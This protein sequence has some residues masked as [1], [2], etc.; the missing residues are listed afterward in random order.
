MVHNDTRPCC[1]GLCSAISVI[2]ALV[3]LSMSMGFITVDKY[4]EELCIISGVSTPMKQPYPN[5]TDQWVSCNCGKRCVTT[6]P[7]ERIYLDIEDGVQHVLALKHTI[8]ERSDGTQCT[9]KEDKCDENGHYERM[10]ES[11]NNVQSFIDLMNANKTITCYINED[12][13]KAY[14][15]NDIDWTSFIITCSLLGVGI[16][17]VLLFTECCGIFK[18]C[19]KDKDKDTDKQKKYADDDDMEKGCLPKLNCWNKLEDV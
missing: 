13:N 6:T 9:S 3:L 19:N 15:N 1:I 5:N 2:S 7:C 11:Q 10:I 14:L 8:S 4:T 18:K 17:G 16:L 12:R